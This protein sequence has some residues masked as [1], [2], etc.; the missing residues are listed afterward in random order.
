MGS[1][2]RYNVAFNELLSYL[3][4]PKVVKDSIHFTFYTRSKT[5][6][7][8]GFYEWTSTYIL[9][10]NDTV[11]GL[12]LCLKAIQYDSFDY[13]SF[14]LF[15]RHQGHVNNIHQLEVYPLWKNSHTEPDGTKL[16]GSHIHKLTQT[17]EVRPQGYEKFDWHDWLA[18]YIGEANITLSS[19]TT[20]IAPPNNGELF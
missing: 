11:E 1:E 17:D 7:P 19:P 5:K 20:A 6:S 18:Y 16:Y 3:A 2:R 14:R 4:M 13:Y 10:G 8:Y 15:Y 9:H 12:Y